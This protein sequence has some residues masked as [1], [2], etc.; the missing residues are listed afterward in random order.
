M[1]RQTLSRRQFLAAS[2][3][4]AAASGGFPYLSLGAIGVERP[5]KRPLGRTGFEVTMRGLGGQAAIQWTP[6]GVAL[7]A[8]I[9]KAQHRPVE[10][11]LSVLPANCPHKPNGRNWQQ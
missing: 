4:A 2:A 10:M 7:L 3:T 8:I 9:A 5:M 11:P 6:P 1:T